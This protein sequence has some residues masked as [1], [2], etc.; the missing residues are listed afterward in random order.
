MSG[1][2]TDV[3]IDLNSFAADER[4]EA[5]AGWV[6]RAWPGLRVAKAEGTPSGLVRMLQLDRAR[7]WSLIATSHTV[8]SEPG[9]EGQ[10][11]DTLALILVRSGALQI[12]HDEQA[13]QLGA[14]DIT[15]LQRSK[16]FRM[17]HIGLTRSLVCEI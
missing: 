3:F 4:A 8:V 5:W 9:H 10:A 16:Q 15:V 1:E 12:A 7:F 13:I 11:D 14:G 2:G 6:P 17:E